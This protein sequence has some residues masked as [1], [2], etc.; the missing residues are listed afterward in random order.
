MAITYNKYDFDG[1]VVIVTGCARGIGR[2]IARAFGENGAKVAAVDLNLDGARET[3]AGFDDATAWSCDI[4]DEDACRDLVQK[5]VD[6]YGRLD[7]L[8]NNA[9]IFTQAPVTEMSAHDWHKL[10][11]VNVD[12]LFFLTKYAMPHL[13]ETKGNIVQT[14][15]VNGIGGD[16]LSYAYNATKHAVVGMVRSLCI[17]YGPKGVRINAVAPAMTATDMNRSVWSVPEKV[18]PFVERIPMARIGQVEDIARAV[19]FLASDDAGY[20]TGQVLC[21]DGGVTASDGQAPGEYEEK[22]S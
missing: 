11:A 19:M 16:Y 3:V 5:V 14:A 10:F 21:V 7:V 13:I 4:S 18:A 2:A 17:D 6:H 8:M 9:G 22:I 15:S 1:K 20:I 12:S